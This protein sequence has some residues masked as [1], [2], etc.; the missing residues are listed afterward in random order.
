MST[1]RKAHVTLQWLREIADALKAEGLTHP[2]VTVTLKGERL[3]T[4][5]TDHAEQIIIRDDATEQSIRQCP[6]DAVLKVL[7]HKVR[8]FRHRDG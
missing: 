5:V 3:V 1:D 4:T 6:V 2:E 7:I 8:G